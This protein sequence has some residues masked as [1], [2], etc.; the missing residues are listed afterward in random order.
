MIDKDFTITTD[1]FGLKIISEHDVENVF[2][3]MNCKS[4][5]EIVSF[6]EWPMTK[7]QAQ[8][9]CN[10]SVEGIS[11]Q[12]E[13]LFIAKDGLL[14]IGC[15]GVHLQKDKNVAEIGYWVAKNYQGKGYATDMAKA[16]VEFAFKSL[17]VK[18]LFAVADQVN[19]GSFRVLEKAGFLHAGIKDVTLPDGS[20]RV[21]KLYELS[22][23]D[24][25]E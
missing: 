20:I 16:A 11:N 2:E 25:Q 19:A 6:L 8:K 4:T 10:K 13:Y 17:Q 15:T 24:L 21:S 5:A 23:G 9:W 1:R 18:K 7:E 3:T 12:T 22:K 14:N